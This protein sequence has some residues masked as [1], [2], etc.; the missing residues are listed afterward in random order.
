MYKRTIE[1]VGKASWRLTVK[2]NSCSLMALMPET[3]YTG[4]IWRAS[5]II[6]RRLYTLPRADEP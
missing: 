4:H 3:A 6:Y 1:Q 5:Q 2:L